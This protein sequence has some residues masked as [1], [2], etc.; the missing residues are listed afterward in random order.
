MPTGKATTQLLG[1]CSTLGTRIF[2]VSRHTAG[3]S[4]ES[5]F[6]PRVLPCIIRAVAMEQQEHTYCHTGV[7]ATSPCWQHLSPALLGLPPAL[8]QEGKAG[9]GQ[10]KGMLSTYKPK[11]S[12]VC[13]KKLLQYSIWSPRAFTSGL[14]P[15]PLAQEV[16]WLCYTA[17][18]LA[19]MESSFP[20][21]PKLESGGNFTPSPRHPSNCAAKTKASLQ[22]E[23]SQLY[24]GFFYTAVSGIK[25]WHLKGDIS[26]ETT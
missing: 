13:G 10:R 19:S 22:Q 9:N 11:R 18:S 21:G 2:H 23:S 25:H 8:K 20:H 17:G 3:L 14:F 1:C 6:A 12:Y 24:P 7:P 15:L 26:L 16:M 4:S 5:H